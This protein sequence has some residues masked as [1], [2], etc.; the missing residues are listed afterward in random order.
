[1]WQKGVGRTKGQVT[2]LTGDFLSGKTSHLA[3]LPLLI[4]SQ[5]WC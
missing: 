5:P 1:M 3:L 4:I 2:F